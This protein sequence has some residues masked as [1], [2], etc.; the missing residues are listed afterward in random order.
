MR[1]TKSLLD[2]S[3]QIPQGFLPILDLMILGKT[4][5]LDIQAANLTQP[6][7]I[8]VPTLILRLLAKL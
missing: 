1:V 7:M 4:P 8:S 5:E 3:G 2:S 6:F